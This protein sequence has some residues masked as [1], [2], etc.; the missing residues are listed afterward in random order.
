MKLLRIVILALILSTGL[1]SA[2]NSPRVDYSTYL[3]WVGVHDTPDY[4]WDV[5]VV[6]DFAYVADMETGVVVVDVTDLENPQEVAVMNTPGSARDMARVGEHLLIADN[7]NRQLVVVSISNPSSPEIANRV[8]IPQWA[9]WLVVGVTVSGDYAYVSAGGVHV[10]DISDLPNATVVKSLHSNFAVADIAVDGDRAFVANL[11]G[12]FSVVDVSHPPLAAWTA[13]LPMPANA[14]G[15]AVSGDHAFVALAGAGIQVMDI[16][17]PDDPQPVGGVYQDVGDPFRVTVSGDLAYVPDSTKG[18]YTVD[19]SDPTSLSIL[20]SIGSAGVGR[21]VFLRRGPR[22]NDAH[23]FVA[24]SSAG[25]Q[26]VDVSNPLMVETVSFLELEHSASG[27]DLAG[28]FAYLGNEDGGFLVID[29]SDPTSPTLRGSVITGLSFQVKV[30][31]GLAYVTDWDNG[32]FVVDV[33][34][35]D[36]PQI[37]GSAAMANGARGIAL[38]EGFAYV[39]GAESGLQVVNIS[40]PMNPQIVYTVDTPGVSVGVALRDPY[41]FVGDQIGGLRIFDVGDVTSPQN[42]TPVTN[43]DLPD[44][45]RFL[46][47]AGDFAYVG[48][49]QGLAVVDISDPAVPILA[50]YLE[51]PGSAMSVKLDGDFAYVADGAAGVLVVDVSDPLQPKVIGNV[52]TPGWVLTSVLSKDLVFATDDEGL[53]ILPKHA[54]PAQ[55]V[56]IDIKPGSDENPINCRSSSGIIPVAILTTDTFDALTIDHETVRFGPGD[57]GEVHFSGGSKSKGKGEAVYRKSGSRPKR[58]EEDVDHDG[59]LDLVFH[60]ALA[61]VG[62]GCGDSEVTLM[63]QTF[64]GQSIVGTDQIRTVPTADPSKD[65]DEVVQISPNPFNPTTTIDFMTREPQ[66]VR[67]GV[68]DVRGRLV[69]E[70]ANG[71]YP[72][73]RH[74]IEWRGQDAAGRAVSSGM[75]LFRIEL[76]GQVH[77]RKALL[78]K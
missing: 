50:A 45:A 25:L 66:R 2:Q 77:L 24:M 69:A 57:A 22:G 30:A 42:P 44:R 36:L 54:V 29:V 51:T 4:A 52:D 11:D 39:G 33:S 34:D 75:Y 15:V 62:I 56:T 74:A 12:G 64:D 46:T 9:N 63:G 71:S 70:L 59:D 1:A 32:L 16:S 58:H 67:I 26:I 21:R 6:E 60:F 10:V 43:L 65:G 13:R 38:A 53:R 47:L 20:G 68:Y 28:D 14:R 40:D 73:G 7:E 35:P 27:V 48:D 78:I 37:M 23:A 61:E 5:E 18:L 72:V 55:E 8:G 76:G 17:N 19:I 31:G 41:V 49:T 3:R